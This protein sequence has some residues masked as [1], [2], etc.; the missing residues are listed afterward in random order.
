LRRNPATGEVTRI[1]RADIR[2]TLGAPGTPHLVLE[3][4]KLDGTA[5]A[6]WRYC[7]DGMNRFVEGKYAVQ[8]EYGV[9][10]GFSCIDPST[11]SVAMAAYI[12]SLDY[13]ERLSCVIDSAGS[14]IT[15]PSPTDPLG[16]HFDT[17]H[18]IA[19]TSHIVL[20][21][22]LIPCSCPPACKHKRKAAGKRKR[23][24]TPPVTSG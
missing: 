24:S 19:T 18:A 9:M 11:E 5:N 10:Y 17:R 15:A 1:A 4:K 14:F 16:A 23:K 8:H 21:H 22:A 12:S 3:F 20:L 6:R 2:V 7:F 13:P